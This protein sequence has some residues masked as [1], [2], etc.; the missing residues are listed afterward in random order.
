MH[1]EGKLKLR[2]LKNLPLE[3]LDALI[4]SGVQS[5]L[6]D[7]FL[8]IGGVKDFADGALGPKTAA[9]LE[10][11]EGGD[12]KRGI[13]LTDAEAIEEWGR[14]ASANGLS[15]TIHAIGDRAN[16]EVLNAFEG[17]RKFE[18]ENGLKAGRHRI[19]HVQIIHEDDLKRLAQLRIG[20]SMQPIHQAS[21]R[22]AAD[23]LWG[24]RSK[25]AYAWK[26]LHESGARLAF[27]SDSPVESPNPLWGLHAAVTRKQH[28]DL[29][30]EAWYGQEAI[31]L[32]QA[33]EAYTVNSAYFAGMETRIGKLDEG[34]LADLIVLEQDLFEVEPDDLPD[35]NPAATM[36]GGKWVW[37]SESANF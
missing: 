34:F 12:G 15:M 33:L 10:P 25:H 4:E 3:A 23:Q 17:V 11:Y 16:H 32:Q 26:S 21:D 28:W 35:V 36:V 27:G 22:D 1:R 29:K 19:E 6:G 7:D 31:S 5:G 9:M 37:K 20:A 8:R 24:K 30:R 14:K 13:L 18:S 2:V